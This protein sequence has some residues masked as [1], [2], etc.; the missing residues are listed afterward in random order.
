MQLLA[1]LLFATLFFIIPRSQDYEDSS[2]LRV[3]DDGEAVSPSAPMPGAV[4]AV[5]PLVAGSIQDA[6]RGVRP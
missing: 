5:E 1:T 6:P 3:F 4:A 2:H